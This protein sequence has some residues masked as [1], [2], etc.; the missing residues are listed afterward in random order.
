MLINPYNHKTGYILSERFPQFDW[1]WG[2]NFIISSR[3]VINNFN[4]RIRDK[5]F[6]YNLI[7]WEKIPCIEFRIIGEGE[8]EIVE[9]SYIKKPPF[10]KAVYVG[11]SE[12]KG[13]AIILPRVEFDEEY[14]VVSVYGKVICLYKKE[15][16]GYYGR[17]RNDAVFKRIEHIPKQ[18]KIISKKIYKVFKVEIVGIDLVKCGN[19][20]L[21]LEINSCP[22]LV[23]KD[24]SYLSSAGKEVVKYLDYRNK[25]LFEKI[26]WRVKCGLLKLKTK[27]RI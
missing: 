13:P 19:K 12:I 22:G 26:K 11:N 8:S 7:K 17:I 21:V 2:G 18:V 27:I 3:T 5:E 15:F 9:D 23:V 14:R 1:N 20:Y 25:S 16:S 24:C 6:M 10:Y 4:Y